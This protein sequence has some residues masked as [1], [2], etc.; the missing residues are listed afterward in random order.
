MGVH[1]WSIGGPWEVHR[2]SIPGLRCAV[3]AWSMGAVLAWSMGAVLA[4]SMGAAPKDN[5]RDTS[6]RDKSSSRDKRSSRDNNSWR[7][8]VVVMTIVV[9]GTM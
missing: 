8:I 9:L 1:R 3:L 2:G 7:A 4:W 6:S 5:S